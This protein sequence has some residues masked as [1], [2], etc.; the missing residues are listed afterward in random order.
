M[1]EL[2]GEHWGRYM[3]ALTFILILLL[4]ALILSFLYR[5][6][7]AHDYWKNGQPVP[8]WVKSSCC[9]P[10]DV[11]ELCPVGARGA[12]APAGCDPDNRYWEEED[13]IHIA[14]YHDGNVAVPYDRVLPSQDGMAWA[15]YKRHTD[16]QILGL[17][18]S[19]CGI[20]GGG[21]CVRSL[22]AEQLEH[23]R[24]T[25]IYCLFVPFAA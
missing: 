11:H 19:G 5:P 9:G 8:A 25:P 1:S 14:G 16:Q 4:A 22:S 17:F 3:R 21:N 6:S 10:E 20:Y 24:F 18:N 15:F 12:P 13:G 2:V 7:S 23:F